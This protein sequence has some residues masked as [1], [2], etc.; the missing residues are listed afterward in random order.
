[1]S[2]LHLEAH[3]QF[4][5]APAPGADLLVL[6]GDIGSYQPGS[7]LQ[8]EATLRYF[9]FRVYHAR[10]WTLPDFRANQSAEQQAASKKLWWDSEKGELGPAWSDPRSYSGGIVE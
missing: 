5:V 2:D 10:L 7:R 8:G 3:P 9:G 6:A 4:Q 1:M